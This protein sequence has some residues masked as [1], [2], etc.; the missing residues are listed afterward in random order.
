MSPTPAN[1]KICYIEIPATDIE[2]SA[3]FYTKVFGWA[4]RKRGDG[5]LAFDDTTGQV[6]GTWVTGRPPSNPGL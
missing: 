1:G 4:T 2:R 3:E 6:S 5:R